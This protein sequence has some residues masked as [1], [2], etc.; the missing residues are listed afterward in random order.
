MCRHLI[1]ERTTGCSDRNSASSVASF[2]SRAYLNVYVQLYFEHFHP[3][4]PFL[5]VPTFDTGENNWLLILSVA[6]VGCQYSATTSCP[7]HA[8]IFQQTC[9]SI[10]RKD[11]RI[12]R[13]SLEDDC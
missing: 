4:M 11:V 3:R 9:Q 7:Q 10:L 2:P 8:T 6:A 13:L 12:Q 1:L 5:H